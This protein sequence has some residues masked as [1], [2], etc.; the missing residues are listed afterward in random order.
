[1][2][3][4][5]VHFDKII[6]TAFRNL[7]YMDGA[8]E[9]ERKV[10]IRGSNFYSDFWRIEEIFR[11]L[12]SN[13]IKYRNRSNSQHLVEIIVDIDE[14][15]ARITFSDNGIG[16]SRQDLNR[17]FDMFYRASEQSVGS[18]LGLYIVKIAIDKLGGKVT[19]NSELGAGTT[20]SLVLPNRIQAVLPNS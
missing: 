13:A 16:I 19:V 6:D 7:S 9:V 12:V 20:F 8:G 4:G 5:L 15:H 2:K 10:I 3:N 1:V 14:N 17:V 11:N 18:G